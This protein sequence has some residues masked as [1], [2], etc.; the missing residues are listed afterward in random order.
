MN[1]IDYS[2]YV[3]LL[4][5]R[6]LSVEILFRLSIIKDFEPLPLHKFRIQVSTP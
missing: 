3:Q 4:V 2:N 6:M 1:V 5:A